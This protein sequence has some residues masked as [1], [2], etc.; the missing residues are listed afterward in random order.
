MQQLNSITK[1]LIGRFHLMGGVP[2]LNPN[3]K[4]FFAVTRK[5]FPDSAIWL[6]T[7]GI[8]LET[9]PQEF[10]ESCKENNIEIHQTKYPIKID[11]NLIEAQC[12]TYG[13]PLIFFNNAKIEKNLAKIC[14]RTKGKLQPI[15]EFYKM[16]NGE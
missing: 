12:K 4:D 1:G 11:W 2:L 14:L 3:C 10:W 13:I 7:N 8:L 16:W 6:V 5:F 15:G 9:Q